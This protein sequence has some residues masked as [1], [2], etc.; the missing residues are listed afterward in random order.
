M[1]NESV[2]PNRTKSGTLAE[3][4]QA[5]FA[6]HRL[7]DGT[8]I[9]GNDAPFS[10]DHSI[11]VNLGE[12]KTGSVHLSPPQD[13]NI[14]PFSSTAFSPSSSLPLK[15]PVTN[16]W[17]AKLLHHFIVHCCP[18]IDVCDS[19]CHFEK[20][21]P[22]RAAHFPVILNGILGLASRHL[23]LTSRVPE[24]HSQPYIDSCLQA[25]IVILEDPL[26]HWDENF[27]VAVSVTRDFM[28]FREISLLAL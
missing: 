1:L 14:S 18:W 15:W 8:V 22:R 25:L 27:L 6:N 16:A 11:N 4:N 9:E 2:S 20:E 3:S 5:T 7:I 26:A 12:A 28:S 19:R 10:S 13:V 17:E 24:D 23:W 21:V